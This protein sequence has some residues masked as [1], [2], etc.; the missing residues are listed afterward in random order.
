MNKI[1]IAIVCLTS[2][3]WLPAG[4][5]Q[6]GRAAVKITPPNGMIMRG[7]FVLKPG[8][9]HDELYSKALV[10]EKDGAK[11]ALVVCDLIG[12][13][14]SVVEQ[15]RQLIQKGSGI[16]GERV[17]ISGTHI[18]TGPLLAGRSRPAG[19]STAPAVVDY[20]ASL[21]GKIAESVR[22]AVS[23]LAPARVS[24]GIGREPSLPFNRRFLMKDGSVQF[25]PGKLN[26]NIVKA[27]GPVDP[28]VA[29]VF[30]DSPGGAPLV[31]YVN[32]AMHLDTVGGD[33]I[34]ADYPYTLATLLGKA[35][36][37]EM[38]TI[39][40]TGTCGNVNHV[41]VKSGTPQ[42]GHA[43]AERIGTTLAQ[44]VLRTYPRL[45]PLSAGA[46]SSRSEIVKMPLVEISPAEVEKA[47]AL[48]ARVGGDRNALPF[49]DRVYAGKVLDIAGRGS[50][51]MDA[52]VQVIALGNQLAWVGL[53]GEI[54]VELGM[55]IKKASPFP[56]TIVAELAGDSIGYVPNREAYPQQAYEVLNARGAAGSGEL[57]VESAVR[58]LKDLHR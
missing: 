31:T 22:Q 38:L 51:T 32:F 23:R 28:S 15:A 2:A 41:D 58:T 25:N 9:I 42:K 6:V 36:G 7:D 30:F 55:A 17:M 53:P 49:L 34:S 44:E 57:L 14:R 4:D 45:Q 37:P 39:F 26:P 43:E 56:Y 3:V 12:V 52:E 16:P 47:N 29:V 46:L 27:V 13:S 24:A 40:S 35:K 8:S 19:G 20:T 1:A 10:V 18:H 48:M 11:A 33:Q 21:P 54:F 50:R 5:L